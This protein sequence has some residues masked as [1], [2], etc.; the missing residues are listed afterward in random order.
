VLERYELDPGELALFELAC[1][2]VDDVAMARETIARD[3][4]VSVGRYGQPIAH[5]AV[6]IARAAE[7]NVARIV[8]Q[9]NVIDPVIRPA[10]RLSTPGPK[11]ASRRD[12]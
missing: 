2:G 6:A 4:V 11:P 10:R 8:G 12:R 5:P 9:L 7:A 1:Q 3:G